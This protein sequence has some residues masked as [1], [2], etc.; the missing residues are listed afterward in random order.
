MF[1][2]RS[3][4]VWLVLMAVEVVHGTRHTLLMAPVVGDF[5]A[6]R[7]GGDFCRELDTRCWEIA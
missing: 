1:L 3:F 7:I 5:L 4:V 2:Q 6:R